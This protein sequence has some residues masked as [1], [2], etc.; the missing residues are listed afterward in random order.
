VRRSR[1]AWRRYRASSAGL[2]AAGM[3]MTMERLV[4]LS[5][6]AIKKVNYSVGAWSAPIKH[7]STMRRWIFGLYGS[8]RSDQPLWIFY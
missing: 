1:E 4:R 5:S 6:L 3:A 2:G 7:G 8:D